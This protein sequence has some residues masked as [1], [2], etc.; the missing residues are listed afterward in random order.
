[1]LDPWWSA[2]F[3]SD[4]SDQPDRSDYIGPIRRIRPIRPINKSA[5]WH[6]ADDDLYCAKENV[7]A[8]RGESR[9]R[10]CS[11]LNVEAGS[12]FQLPQAQSL[13]GELLLDFVQ[14]GRS[15]ILDTQ[16]FRF[17]STDQ[18]RNVVDIQ[19]IQRS[20]RSHRKIQI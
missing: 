16:Q 8:V 12:R 15:E 4:Q 20:T 7:Y 17:G 13:F 10:L 18:V 6:C 19:Q 14:A 3:G 5:I 2:W 1:M 9:T 11:N